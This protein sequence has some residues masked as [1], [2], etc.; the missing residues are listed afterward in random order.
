MVVNGSTSGSNST[1]SG[2]DSIH[3]SSGSDCCK[4]VTPIAAFVVAVVEDEGAA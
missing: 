3:G 2:S 1:G 4:G